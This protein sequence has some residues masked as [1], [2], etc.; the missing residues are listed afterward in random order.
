MPQEMSGA[1]LI[2]FHRT[3]DVAEIGRAISEANKH[4]GIIQT[5]E[6]AEQ[7]AL[8]EGSR[9][10]PLTAAETD[11]TKDSVAHLLEK[12]VSD[13]TAEG[14]IAG[15]ETGSAGMEYDGVMESLET[16]DHVTSATGVMQET[17]TAE[18][19]DAKQ[20]GYEHKP[21]IAVNDTG[22]DGVWFGIELAEQRAD[23][24]AFTLE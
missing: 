15:I 1:S 4:I 10:D 11:I 14:V 7:T 2:D 24:E 9:P 18:Q 16:A 21:E 20:V 12:A 13:P 23:N 17:V 6:S 8:G 19:S 5:M 22:R 3:A